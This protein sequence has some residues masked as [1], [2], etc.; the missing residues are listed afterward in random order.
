MRRRAIAVVVGVAILVAAPAPA[1]AHGIG[2]RED[3]PVP[4]GIF[5]AGAGLAIV[6]S[7]IVVSAN[8]REPRLQTGPRDRFVDAPLIRLFYRMLAVIGLAG[9][10]LAVGGGLID[11][12]ASRNNIAPVLVWVYFWLVV[13]FASVLLGDLWRWMSPW[14]MLTRWVNHDRP[15]RPELLDDV[16]YWPAVLAFVAFT[17]LELVSPDSSLPR[18]LAIAAIV[19]TLY[20]VAI[21]YWAGPDTGLEIGGA[22]ANYNRLLGALAPISAEE[23]TTRVGVGAATTIETRAFRIRR[24]G[25]LRSLPT[26]PTRPGLAPFVV[27]MIGTVTYDGMSST[28]WWGDV[29]GS[30][31]RETWFGTAAL[32]GTIVVLGAAYY[33]ASSAATRIAGSELSPSD[34][35]RSFAHTLVP[36]A[37]AYAFAHYFT[38]IVYE[39]QQLVRM[40]SDP[41]GLGWDLFGTADWAIVF[42]SSTLWIWYIQ[43]V[44]IVAGHIGGVVLAHDRA[45]AVFGER[46]AARSQYAMLVLMV[47]LTSLGLLILAG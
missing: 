24:G 35:A 37:F 2:G 20:K 10:A 27:A 18:T 23:H 41:F 1:I 21:T 6:I 38:L 17:W 30:A 13:P 34:I 11:G 33:A 26:L 42:A 15:E 12:A 9:F 16:G 43:L 45:L 3:L 46:D 28:G 47:G 44:A 7:F 4:L 25:W 39:G 31:G 32:V 5:V 36:I 8:W 19:Y 40:A 14:R 29:T 22:F